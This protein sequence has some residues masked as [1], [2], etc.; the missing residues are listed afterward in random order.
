LNESNLGFWYYKLNRIGPERATNDLSSGLRRPVKNPW[1]IKSAYN[2]KSEEGTPWQ[3]M[4]TWFKLSP[5]PQA[6]SMKTR[7]H[8]K[9]LDLAQIEMLVDP[10][11]NGGSEIDMPIERWRRLPM[12]LFIAITEFINE[13]CCK[14][15]CHFPDDY[16]QFAKEKDMFQMRKYS[17]IRESWN[18]SCCY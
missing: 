11:N 16:G 1:L 3:T 9:S 4:S 14:V 12:E 13:K 18:L 7:H 6:Q 10:L 8:E 15:G 2:R 17:L 5:P